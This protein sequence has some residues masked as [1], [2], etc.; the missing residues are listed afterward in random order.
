[1]HIIT[2]Y[3][4]S[5]YELFK[6]DSII[7]SVYGF[8]TELRATDPVNMSN[9]YSGENSIKWYIE[10]VEVAQGD[11][12]IGIGSDFGF[13]GTLKK[14]QV[15]V[16]DPENITSLN[17]SGN[18]IKGAINIS[19][20]GFGSGSTLNLAN[21]NITSIIH[22]PDTDQIIE[23]YV[24]NDNNL[25]GSLNLGKVFFETSADVRLFN[26]P[27][28]IGLH[29][30]SSVIN[31]LSSLSIYGADLRNTLD[32]TSVHFVDNAIVTIKDN[33]FLQNINLNN[34]PLH[35]ISSINLSNNLL[36]Y[37]DLTSIDYNRVG[38]YIDLSGNLISSLNINKILSILTSLSPNLSGIGTLLIQ[39][40]ALPDNNSGEFDGLTALNYLILN[41]WTISL[42]VELDTLNA[43]TQK[44][45]TAIFNYPIASSSI[46]SIVDDAQEIEHYA[47]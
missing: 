23:N 14:V 15:N 16:D 7:D 4:Y 21:N 43:L 6:K 17:L 31:S 24:V 34:F 47:N 18:K 28:L 22:N 29:L 32:L 41:D 36:N 3:N 44:D 10:G 11:S 45:Q 30:N 9:I 40:N 27:S 42:N 19:K 37:F 33:N 1:M 2:Q 38:M 26:N 39:G 13:D 35:S 12:L 8:F 20:I 46:A 5:P 25:T